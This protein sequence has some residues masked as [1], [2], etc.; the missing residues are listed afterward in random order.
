[1]TYCV[2]AGIL[3]EDLYSTRLCYQH[4]LVF[5]WSPLTFVGSDDLLCYLWMDIRM[6]M[7]CYYALRGY[8]TL[9]ALIGTALPAQEP[10]HA[11]AYLQLVLHHDFRQGYLSSLF[12]ELDMIFSCFPRPTFEIPYLNGF[13]VHQRLLQAFSPPDLLQASPASL[14][15]LEPVLLA[16]PLRNA[17]STT[18]CTAACYHVHAATSSNPR[19]CCLQDIGGK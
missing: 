11:E 5:F 14:E 1:M 2:C 7:D 10:T 6:H 9:G 13:R 3:G 8:Y 4:A 12:P 18:P 15:I 19:G 16:H 17:T